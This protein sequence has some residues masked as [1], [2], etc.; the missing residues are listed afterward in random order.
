MTSAMMIALGGC[1]TLP[2]SGPT[3]AQIQ[4]AAKETAAGLAFPIV[5]LSDL[6]TLPVD[7]APPAVPLP[8][9]EAPPT[10]LIGIGDVL[11][12]SIYEAG[13]SLFGRDSIATASQSQPSTQIER[14]PSP[15]VDDRG[16]IRIPFAGPVAA[17]GRTTT[18]LEAAIRSALRGKSENPQVLVTVRE[19]VANSIILSGEI[20]RPGRLPLPTNRETLSDA[21]ALA[22]GYRG[23]A[24]DLAVR[25]L[26]EETHI[27]LRLNDI[28]SGSARDFRVYP[29]DRVSLIRQPW[30]F[31]SMG[32]SGRADQIAF[33]KASISLAEAV[34]LAGGANPNLGDPKAIFVFRFV[35]GAAGQQEPVVYHLNMMQ[36][37]AYLVSQRFMMRDKDLLYVGNARANQP[38]KFIQI[39][40]QLFTPALLTREL[41]R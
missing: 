20:S 3:G 17:A 14:I 10:D 9:H 18:E 25:V 2:S 35:D 5:E 36:A 40:G 29:G 23:E 30:F 34:A 4:N 38:T 19:V 1:A 31:S 24:K 32:A 12:I 16:A 33:P 7:N 27:D 21:I 26:R 39:L 37:G 22:G 28:L 6:S 8:E 41:T 11:D 13:V 15:R